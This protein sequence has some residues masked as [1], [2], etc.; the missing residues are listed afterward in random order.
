MVGGLVYA[1]LITGF[2]GGVHCLGMCGGIVAVINATPR[3]ASP[4]PAQPISWSL[5]PNAAGCGQSA[6]ARSAGY[7]L[8]RLGTYALLGAVAGTLGSTAMLA[9]FALPVQEVMYLAAAFMLVMIG[10]QLAGLRVPLLGHIEAL[11]GRAWARVRPS[12]HAL[13]KGT[14]MRRGLLAGLAWGAVPCALVYST[15]TLAVLAGS[16]QGGAL[17]MLAFG[18]GT[19]PHLTLGALAARRASRLLSRPWLRRAAGALVVAMAVNGAWHGL[20]MHDVV[21]SVATWCSG[22][23]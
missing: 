12:A 20:H 15:L 3:P 10:I 16:T 19:L 2:A 23:A 5:V 17:V 6:V 4:V 1:A 11:G 14:G 7:H 18:A 21:E 9:R 13:L 22:H 8:G